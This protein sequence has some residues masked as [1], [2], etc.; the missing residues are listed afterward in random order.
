ML[1]IIIDDLFHY[2]K[3]I[4][5]NPYKKMYYKKLQDFKIK[6]SLFSNFYFEFIYLALN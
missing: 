2:L 6:T 3:N 4:L 5:N 1:F